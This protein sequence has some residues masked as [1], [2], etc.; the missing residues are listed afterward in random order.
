MLDTETLGV[1]TIDYEIIGRQLTPYD[2]PDKRQGN[3]QSERAVQTDGR[4]PES[5]TNNRWNVEAQKGIHTE[6]QKAWELY[7]QEAGSDVQKQCN[8]DNTTKPSVTPNPMT[9][10]KITKRIPSF[11]S[12]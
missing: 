8:V 9:T 2:N 4:K 11:Q 6:G 12:L 10:G 7:K 5:C 3:Y 1:L